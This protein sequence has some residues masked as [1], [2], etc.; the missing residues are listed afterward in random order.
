MRLHVNATKTP[1]IRAYIQSSD[2]SIREL[3][4]E[5]GISVNTVRHWRN[6]DTIATS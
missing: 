6:R 4:K 3:A 1:K 2:K 5:L